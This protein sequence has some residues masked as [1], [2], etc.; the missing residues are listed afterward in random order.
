MAY[1]QNQQ[2]GGYN[3]Q[4]GGGY[5]P[6]EQPA[7]YY[8]Q[9]QPAEQ[10][11]QA[12][13]GLYQKS[14]QQIKILNNWWK[15]KTRGGNIDKTLVDATEKAKLAQQANLPIKIVEYWLGNTRKKAR[16]IARTEGKL[17]P[18]GA[19]NHLATARLVS[20]DRLCFFPF[21]TR[22]MSDFRSH[23]PCLFLAPYRWSV[24][25]EAGEEEACLEE[26]EACREGQAWQGTLALTFHSCHP[27][28]PGWPSLCCAMDVHMF[29]PCC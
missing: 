3:Q 13:A 10:E 26:E 25:Q 17:P 8:Q 5:A 22:F 21:P 12:R 2:Y 4:Y 1:Q 19:E 9:E 27:S 16:K 11:K 18:S 24:V 23:T 6:Q 15:K 28:T 20:R 29:N 14:E 7:Q